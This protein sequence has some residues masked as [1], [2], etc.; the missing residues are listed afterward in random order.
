MCGICGIVHHDKD[1]PVDYELLRSVNNVMVHRGPDDEG[2]HVEP[3]VGLA[4]RRLAIV[5]LS[6]GRQ[7][8]CNEDGSIW[9]V[10]N[11]EIYNHMELR[12]QL[13][14]KGHTLHTSCDTEVLVHLYE[15][16]GDRFPE[17]LIGMFAIAIWDNKKRRLILVRDR[18]GIKPLYF[19]PLDG[20]LVFASELKAMLLY[21][22]IGRE[23]DLMAFSEYLTFQHTIPPRTMIA[24]IRKL[25]AGNIAVYEHGKL[26]P[27][28]YWDL[29]FPL[30]QPSDSDEK[31][32]VERFREALTTSVRRRLMSDV[33]LGVFLSGG[34]DSSSIVAMMSQLGVDNI[35]TY[36]LGYAEGD[37]YGELNQAS[38]VSKLFKTHHNELII[39]SQDYQEAIPNFIL[40]MD[41]PVS[42]TAGL[43][44]MLLAKR[45]REDVTVI[46]SG[47]GADE[48]WG[49]YT[50]DSLQ[51]RFDRLRRF[52]LLP[53][54]LRIGIP[55][56]MAPL[57]PH[58][59]R[60]WLRRGNSDISTINAEEAHTLAW[61]FE[62][63]EKR[64]FCPILRE[65]KEHC[66]EVVRDTYERSGT[67]DPLYQVLYVYTKIVLAENLLMHGDKMTMAH[68]VELR[69]PF[70]DH[71][72][73]ELV[74]QI[75][76][77]YLIR[78]ETNGSY[79]TKSILKRAMRG[80]L[81]ETILARPKA[82]FPIPLKEWL[83]STLAAYCRDVLLSNSAKSSGIYDVKQVEMLLDGHRNTPTTKSTLQIK[84]LLFFE[85]WRQRFLYDK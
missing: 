7:P 57:I 54:W 58:D 5:D 33:P 80:I 59:T 26:E 17:F 28:E 3:G 45:A 42:D 15:E 79:T 49:G 35:R 13:K 27:R 51:R 85:M 23:I 75:P 6:G 61:Q 63:E 9:V 74:T 10:F 32:C 21:P 11:G 38:Q 84:N 25:A 29:R 71:E 30:E 4:M 70:L 40:N 72:L 39:S 43:L 31:L 73:V 19:A 44:F 48:V 14:A 16:E 50:L 24:G 62:T 66:Q 34:I 83:Q 64:R 2:Y 56:I 77:R 55:S 37:L 69:V 81:P 76:S 52:Q 20:T 60:E 78:R 8:M 12:K 53:R 82:A 22:D 65:V 18:L 47:Q 67:K 36:S 46:L 1:R 68:S 41:D